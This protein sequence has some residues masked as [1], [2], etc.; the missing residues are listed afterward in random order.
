MEGGAPEASVTI[1]SLDRLDSTC[2]IEF[3]AGSLARV[4]SRWNGAVVA[5]SRVT[6]QAKGMSVGDEGRGISAYNEPR[7]TNRRVAP[8][9]RRNP[10]PRPGRNEPCP[11]ESGKKFKQCCALKK[12]RLSPVLIAVLVAGAVLV[13]IVLISNVRRSSNA[14]MV[15][16]P[17]H[18][19]YHN[20]SGGEI[21]R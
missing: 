2:A 16:S 10:M 18:G 5:G 1:I 19:H 4:A 21:P 12:E 9:S 3:V 17:E 8:H 11:C 14:G 15:W 20:A 7:P 6:G 13:V